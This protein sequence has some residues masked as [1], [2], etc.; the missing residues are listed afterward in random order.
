MFFLHGTVS[1]DMVS[2]IPMALVEEACSL[3]KK[4]ST[5]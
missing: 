2:G 3:H 1:G 4:Y 5:S